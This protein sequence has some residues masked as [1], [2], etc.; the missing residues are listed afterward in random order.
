MNSA[1]PTVPRLTR[2]RGFTLIELMIT[3]AIVAMLAAIAIPSY[4]D[5]VRKG[6]RGEGKAAIL[7]AL[8][9]EERWFTQN[10]AYTAYVSTGTPPSPT[11][12]TFS[13]DNL[14]N[15]RYTI[16]VQSATI[17]GLCTDANLTRCAI[18]VATRRTGTDPDCGTFLAMDTVGNKVAGAPNRAICW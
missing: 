5:S 11:F 15:S 17:A 9:A 8:Q 2:A 7:K 3:V 13:A 14:N 18:V 16:A 6:E 12:P 1:H 4:R 10:N